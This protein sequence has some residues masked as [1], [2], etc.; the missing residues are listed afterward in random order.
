MR[1]QPNLQLR[2]PVQ[3]WTVQRSQLLALRALRIGLWLQLLKLRLAAMRT[4]IVWSAC[5]RNLCL[6]SRKTTKIL[7]RRRACRGVFY[8]STDRHG[9]AV[10][11]LEQVLRPLPVEFAGTCIRCSDELFSQRSQY[12]ALGLHE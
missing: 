7:L 9:N 12:V 4:A 6:S 2:L 5:S 1:Q 10:G 11:S 8:G 3:Q